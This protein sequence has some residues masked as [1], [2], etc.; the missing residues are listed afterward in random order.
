MGILEYERLSVILF[1]K[2]RPC[3]GRAGTKSTGTVS[4]VNPSVGFK[5]LTLGNASK[6]PDVAATAP[7][8]E[9]VVT[10]PLGKLSAKGSAEVNAGI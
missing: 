6:F 3:C 7:T 5:L 4:G 10:G 8:E 1:L 2:G 9:E